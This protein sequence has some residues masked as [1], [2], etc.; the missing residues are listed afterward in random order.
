VPDHQEGAEAA[1]APSILYHGLRAA[2]SFVTSMSISYAHV[3][4]R[5]RRA[6][7]G[8]PG[9]R[10]PAQLRRARLA[11]DLLHDRDGALADERDR[12]RVGAH[13]LARDAAG[14]VGCTQ[15]VQMT[16]AGWIGLALVVLFFASWTFLEYVAFRGVG[17][18]RYKSGSAFAEVVETAVGVHATQGA[19]WEA[20]KKAAASG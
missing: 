13:A 14:S 18:R 1:R 2:G 12:H 15:S 6:W 19:A 7:H 9:L 20:L 8:A 5:C 11:G 16:A 3:N 17:E 4:N 10:P